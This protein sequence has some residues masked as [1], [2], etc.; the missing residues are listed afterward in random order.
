MQ[1]FDSEADYRTVVQ[2]VSHCQQQ[3]YFKTT[4]TRTIL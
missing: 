3:S 1:L 2:N 4:L